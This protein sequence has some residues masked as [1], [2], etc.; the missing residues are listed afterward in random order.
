MSHARRKQRGD[1]AD[2]LLFAHLAIVLCGIATFSGFGASI[3][4]GALL[5]LLMVGLMLTAP[6]IRRPACARRQFTAHAVDLPSAHAGEAQ[7]RLRLMAHIGRCAGAPPSELRQGRLFVQPAQGENSIVF[8]L[9]VF[10]MF[11][12]AFVKEVLYVCNP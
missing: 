9:F 10:L 5:V 2:R 7:R 11:M 12:P 3:Q 8:T 1:Y 6:V 4:L